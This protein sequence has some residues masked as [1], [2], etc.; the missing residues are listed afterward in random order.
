MYAIGGCGCGRAVVS[1]YQVDEI[2][3]L[4]EC[5]DESNVS[6]DI[7]LFVG[8]GKGVGD[9][10]REG[11]GGHEGIKTESVGFGCLLVFRGSGFGY[12]FWNGGYFWLS[13][14]HECPVVGV[15]ITAC[16]VEVSSIG[17]QIGIVQR[18][19]SSPGTA[20]KAADISPPLVTSGHVLGKVRI[21]RGHHIRV[22][23]ELPHP[24]AEGFEFGT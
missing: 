8:K 9:G 17:P 15:E 2:A 24:A 10:F 20:A 6:I 1:P 22:Q 21:V 4:V 13:F 19:Q 3:L 23:T 12:E 16:F 5:I 18:D 11:G 14:F 7:V